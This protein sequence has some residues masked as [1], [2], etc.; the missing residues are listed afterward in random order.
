MYVCHNVSLCKRYFGGIL[1]EVACC[2]CV[3]VPASVFRC[4]YLFICSVQMCMYMYMYVYT[5]D[6]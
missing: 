3:I 5:S 6:C 4:V 2:E 1:T